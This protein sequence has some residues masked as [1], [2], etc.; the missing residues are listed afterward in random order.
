LVDFYDDTLR[1]FDSYVGEVIYHLKQTGQ[2]DNTILIIYTDHNQEFKVNERIPLIIHFPNGD[3]AG[4][5]TQNVENMDIAPT[6]LDYLDLPQPTW[7]I[8][9]SML[10]NSL[11]DQRLIFITGTSETKAKAKEIS[12]LDPDLDQPPFYQF[13]YLN[14]IDCRMWYQLDMTTFDWYSEKVIGYINPCDPQDL[15]GPGEIRQAMYQRLAMD[16]FDIS[17][18]P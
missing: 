6:V 12:F 11:M 10:D 17:S 18:L 8:G 7:M 16:G 15:R 9:E 5:I 3:H 2:F 13:S 1:A 14:V 4:R